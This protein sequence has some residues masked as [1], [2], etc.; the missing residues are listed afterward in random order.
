[1]YNGLET[2]METAEKRDEVI[3]TLEKLIRRKQVVLL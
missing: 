1:M 2:Q 3:C